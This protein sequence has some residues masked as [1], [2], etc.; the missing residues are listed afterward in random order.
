MAA[1]HLDN[2]LDDGRDACDVG[3][4]A[5]FLRA[6]KLV[7]DLHRQLAYIDIEGVSND[8]LDEQWKKAWGEGC[9]NSHLPE[10]KYNHAIRY[11]EWILSL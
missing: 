3:Q 1:P 11:A 7:N 10:S 5:R 2:M 4:N 8:I 9:Y 6:N